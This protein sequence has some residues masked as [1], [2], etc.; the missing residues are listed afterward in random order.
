MLEFYL[1]RNSFPSFHEKGSHTVRFPRWNSHLVY[2]NGV[3]I[4]WVLWLVFIA[5]LKFEIE[6]NMCSDAGCFSSLKPN[7]F[8]YGRFSITFVRSRILFS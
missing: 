2:V 6:G 3:I 1:F 8:N 4:V 7:S 5:R